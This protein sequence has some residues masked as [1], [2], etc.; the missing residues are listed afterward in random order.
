MYFGENLSK[1][2]SKHY[3][4]RP[5]DVSILPEIRI[6]ATECLLPQLTEVAAPVTAATAEENHS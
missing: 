1:Q 4:P 3:S 6:F 5:K 2:K